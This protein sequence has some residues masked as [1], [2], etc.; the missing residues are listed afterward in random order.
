METSKVYSA[1]SSK[2]RQ[3]VND[4]TSGIKPVNKEGRKMMGVCAKTCSTIYKGTEKKLEFCW[5]ISDCKRCD[6]C[7][8]YYPSEV[9]E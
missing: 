2:D 3:T 9:K 7:K 8:H 6:D 1:T 4:Q 5:L